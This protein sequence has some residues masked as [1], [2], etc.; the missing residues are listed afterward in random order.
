MNYVPIGCLVTS[1]SKDRKTIRYQFSVL[2]PVDEFKRSLARHIA[3]GRLLE[4]P[5]RIKGLR[6][7]EN[8]WQINSLVME[9]IL[10]SKSRDIPSRARK[11]A[12]LWLQR[13]G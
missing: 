1:L 4:I 10:N 5:F 7:D 3:L 13:H 8:S 2:N 11:S 12:K 6:G 9:D